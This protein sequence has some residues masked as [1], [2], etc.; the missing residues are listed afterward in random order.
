V[1]IYSSFTFDGAKIQ[2]FFDITKTF[3]K[4]KQK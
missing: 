4:K 1:L 3:D 2:D